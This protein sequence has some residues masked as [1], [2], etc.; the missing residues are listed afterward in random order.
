MTVGQLAAFSVLIGATYGLTR[1][2]LLGGPDLPGINSGFWPEC[3]GSFLC[4]LLL[5][6]VFVLQRS[7]SL[8]E[9]C[10]VLVIPLVAT[11]MFLVSVPQAAAVVPSAV[12]TVGFACFFSLLWYF[13]AIQ[14][15]YYKRYGVTFVTSLL[16]F[17]C[18]LGQV[19]GALVPLRASGV[20]SAT[21]IYA[22]LMAVAL[23]VYWHARSS[24]VSD[25]RI[26]RPDSSAAEAGQPPIAAEDLATLW[27]RE[28]GLSPREAQVALLLVQ[29]MPYRQI[30]GRLFVSE[31]T[32][33]THAR[34]IYKKAGVS[35]REELHD[36]LAALS[37]CSGHSL[38]AIPPAPSGSPPL[39]DLAKKG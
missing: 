37:D 21:I 32:V 33:K 1:V 26:H 7:N 8:F 22:L 18:Q 2:F 14:S 19:L 27:E 12:C 34:N 28:L 38:L 13:A 29:R 4:A 15:A 17:A 31:N 6:A 30:A 20:F 9:I 3:L 23:F 11:G 39:S 24:R 35:S 10:L 25:Q 16:F 36:K 5:V